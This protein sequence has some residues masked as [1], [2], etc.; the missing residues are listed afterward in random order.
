LKDGAYF[1]LYQEIGVINTKHADQ[2]SGEIQSAATMKAANQ[3]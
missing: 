3:N 1:V 2:A